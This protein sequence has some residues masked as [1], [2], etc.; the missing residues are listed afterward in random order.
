M[1]NGM[2]AA[3]AV[4]DAAA[5]GRVRRRIRAVVRS[6]SPAAGP[7]VFALGVWLAAYPGATEPA[8]RLPDQEWRTHGGDPGHGQYS[9]LSAVNLSS[10]RLCRAKS[11]RRGQRCSGSL[12]KCTLEN[13]SD[14][15][16]DAQVVCA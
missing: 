11:H 16:E 6:S 8:G 5:S 2:D 7:L 12:L 1:G 4:V 3:G 13:G 14:E 15:G 9:A 10:L